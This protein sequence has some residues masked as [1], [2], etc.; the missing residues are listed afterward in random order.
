MVDAHDLTLDVA[1]P[2]LLL[3]FPHDQNGLTY[4]HRLLVVKLGPGRWV[5]SSPDHELEVLDLTGRQYRVLTRRSA[6]PA[7]IQDRIYAFDPIGRAELERLKR[8]AKAM[9]I[10]LG[11]Q[12]V[13][14]MEANV[15]VFADAESPQ[16]GQTVP[17]DLVAGAV[18][19]SGKGLVEVDGEVKVI[20]EIALSQQAEFAAQRKGVL[21]DLRLIGHHVDSS[22]RRFIALR[23]AFPLLRQSDFKDWQFKGPRAVRE[24]LGSIQESGTDLGNYHLQWVKNSGVNAHTGACHEHRNLVELVRLA[25]CRDQL[26]VT[27]LMSVE[28][29]I[30]RVVQI[31]VAVSRNAG[32][33]DYSGL[34]VLLENPLTETG[35]AATRS[36]DE[37]VTSRLKEK[38]Q[39]AK[40]T[41]L[42]KEE[43][44][45]ASKNK[46]T[47][48]GAEPGGGTW[49]KRK[50]KAK[51]S[52]GAGGAGAGET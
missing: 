23:D 6:F 8:D 12:E 16:L 11:D 26:D 36:L 48:A 51:A 49:R 52:P 39:I 2:Q 33:P 28:L 3:H 19:L 38:A 47:G 27:N 42:F 37:W 31:E 5:A 14:E 29:A 43:S 34:E 44:S 50:P 4:H 45:F 46:G 7:D 13:E 17:Q 32:N 10:I 25:L 21:G 20:E 1:E 9:S 22:D 24:F 18:T 41:R 40:Q 35:A 15:W 30:R